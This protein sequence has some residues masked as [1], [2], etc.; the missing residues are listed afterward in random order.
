MLSR[1][2]SFNEPGGRAGLRGSRFHGLNA[3]QPACGQAE[4]FRA[5][6][7]ERELG[8][9]DRYCGG[10]SAG[11]VL[12]L[13]CGVPVASLRPRSRGSFSPVSRS[14]ALTKKSNVFCRFADTAARVA[15]R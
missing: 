7:V 12:R 5:R 13:V 14:A 11:K 4:A 8:E 2:S 6:G 3:N 10:A 1:P 9:G 15:G